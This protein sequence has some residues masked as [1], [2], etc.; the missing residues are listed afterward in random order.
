MSES[1]HYLPLRVRGEKHE[2]YVRD[3][4]RLLFERCFVG[5][6]FERNEHRVSKLSELQFQQF[7]DTGSGELSYRLITRRSLSQLSNARVR[8]VNF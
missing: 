5:I 8:M 1:G 3:Q 6:S 7:Q 2:N 4:I